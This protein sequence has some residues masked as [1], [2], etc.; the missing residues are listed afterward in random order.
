MGM[1]ND[2]LT[3]EVIKLRLIVKTLIAWLY[4]ELGEDSQK[5]LLQMFEDEDDKNGI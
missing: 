4:L 1:D 3:H 5:K 2:R